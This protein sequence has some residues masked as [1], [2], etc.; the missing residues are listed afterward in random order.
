MNSIERRVIIPEGI[1]V[2]F[3]SGTLSFMNSEGLV[4]VQRVDPVI[5]C[6]IQGQEIIFSIMRTNA[7][8][9]A[10]LNTLVAHSSNHF[11]GLQNPFR[12]DIRIIHKHFPI[13]VSIESDCIRIENFTGR[14]KDIVVLTRGVSVKQEKDLMTITSH[15]LELLGNFYGRIR[16]STKD[17]RDRRVFWDG[18]YIVNKHNQYGTEAT[19]N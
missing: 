13:R 7:K 2:V 6:Y 8:S 16:N 12:W 5:N 10:L 3:E 4:N 15:N 14:K 11:I 9:Y 1:T 17:S 18:F 19:T